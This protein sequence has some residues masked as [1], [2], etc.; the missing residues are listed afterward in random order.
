MI[1][2]SLDPTYYAHDWKTCRTWEIICEY[3]IRL[4]LHLDV[5]GG[6]TRVAIIMVEHGKPVLNM[7]LNQ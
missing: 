2:A 7:D 6:N 4:V 3:L 5:A 1:Y